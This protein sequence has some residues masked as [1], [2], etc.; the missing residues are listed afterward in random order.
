M[1]IIFLLKI[2][3][4]WTENK[5]LDIFFKF[6]LEQKKIIREGTI[7]LHGDNLIINFLLILSF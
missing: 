5:C 3:S 1:R 4:H 7:K 6:N 2:V